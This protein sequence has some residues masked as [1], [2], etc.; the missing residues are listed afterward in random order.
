[1]FCR[2]KCC[3]PSKLMAGCL[4]GAGLGMFL[5]LVLPPPVWLCV[6]SIALIVMGIKKIFEK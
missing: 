4:L 3:K 6:I 2:R 5:I 1:M